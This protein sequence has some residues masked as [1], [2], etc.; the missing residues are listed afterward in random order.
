MQ[1]KKKNPLDAQFNVRLTAIQLSELRRKAFDH[2]TSISTYVR[3]WL[4]SQK[5]ISP[6]EELFS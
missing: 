3:K 5:M 6:T 2:N 1:T 4:E